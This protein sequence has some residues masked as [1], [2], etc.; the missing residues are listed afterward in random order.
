ML[1]LSYVIGMII[2]YI[3]SNILYQHK[4][5]A[6]YMLGRISG[7]YWSKPTATLRYLETRGLIEQ[8]RKDLYYLTEKGETLGKEYRD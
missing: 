1:I 7:G 3:I 6:A 5:K 4:I 8:L 2:G